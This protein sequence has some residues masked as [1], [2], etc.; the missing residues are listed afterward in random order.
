MASMFLRVVRGERAGGCILLVVMM[1][2]LERVTSV[3]GLEVR[4]DSCRGEGAREGPEGE[5]VLD[6]KAGV[7]REPALA[8]AAA[9]F[10]S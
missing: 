2:G 7:D 3:V 9:R 10:G 5:V 1:I 4:G 8:R 6:L